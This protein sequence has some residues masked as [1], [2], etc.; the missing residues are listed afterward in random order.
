MELK[1]V[2]K[3]I[4]LSTDDL[5]FYGEEMA[6]IRPETYENLLKK[7]KGKLILV[8]AVSPTPAGE[9]KTTVSIGLADAMNKIFRETNSEKRAILALREP[10]MGPVFGMKGGAIGGGESVV[11]PGEEINLHFTGDLH[12]ITSANN[13]LAALVD[14]HIY[15]GNELDLDPKKIVFKRCLDVNDRALRDFQHNSAGDFRDVQSDRFANFSAG[16]NITAASEVMA[17]LALS[18]DIDDLKNRLSRIL[19]AFSR[20]GKPVFARD[21]KAENAMTILLKT[22]LNP[23]FVRSKSGTPAFVHAGPFA[24]IA[25]GANSV[26]A[27]KTA[28]ALGDYVITEAGFGSDLGAEKFLDVKM[29][30]SGLWP[31][32]AVLVATVRAL[33]WGGGMRFEDLNCEDFEKLE[34]GLDNLKAHV[35]ILQKF[36]LPVI[37]AINKF[38][39]DTQKELDFICDFAEKLD[40][41]CEVADVFS[42]NSAAG[43][44]GENLA[45]TVINSV[46][47][48]IENS[49][50]FIYNLQDSPKE[51][52]AKI[53][54]EIYGAKDVEY[55]KKSLEF[56]KKLDEN[57]DLSFAKNLPVVIAKTQYSLSD[58]PAKISTNLRENSDFNLRI[59]EIEINSGAGFLVATA[60]TLY[61]MPGLPRVPQSN[62]MTINSDGNV[63]GLK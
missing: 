26:R 39:T 36:H 32:A 51:K 58:D 10:S 56:L 7:P 47:Q 44:N 23:N 4:G 48:N 19:V 53:A 6:K 52:I 62:K 35:K 31:S 5:F 29:R 12:A 34:I 55:S 43:E 37:I 28:L 60:G 2:A 3:G 14:N 46:N 63:S 41:K 24:N 20:S 57:P 33:K 13:L 38:A 40:V 59:R 30:A 27:T 11:V 25:H 18:K 8:S 50:H 9:G 22:A 1:N 17:I 45:K 54:S 16:F 49:P 42:R 21:L 15:F 61:R